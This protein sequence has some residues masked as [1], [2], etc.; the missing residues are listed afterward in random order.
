[1]HIFCSC[2]RNQFWDTCAVVQIEDYQVLVQAEHLRDIISMLRKVYAFKQP[3]QVGQ[4]GPVSGAD[5]CIPTFHQ[6][7]SVLPG[8]FA[9]QAAKPQPEPLQ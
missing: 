4:E 7:P 8:L 6:L 9:Q 2:T 5:F 3:A 1:M